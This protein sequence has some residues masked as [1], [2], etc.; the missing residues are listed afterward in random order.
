MIAS[1]EGETLVLTPGP[2]R[3]VLRLSG[4][5]TVETLAAQAQTRRIILRLG[6]IAANRDPQT[7]YFV[8]LNAGDDVKPTADDLGYA[9]ALSFFGMPKELRE[10]SRAVSFEVSP[11]LVRL[12]QAGRLNSP[13]SATF[14]P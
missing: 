8:F 9:G 2:A 1:W 6:G 14:V 7:G 13:I 5:M 4:N 11:I 12:Q 3:A 10:G